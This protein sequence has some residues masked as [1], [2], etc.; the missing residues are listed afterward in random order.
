MQ[1]SQKTTQIN[2]N[3]QKILVPEDS[4]SLP[5]TFDPLD[6]ALDESGYIYIADR[7][8]RAIYRWSPEGSLI[9]TIGGPGSGPG[10]FEH[11]PI[12]LAIYDD[13]LLAAIDM[14]TGKLLLYYLKPNPAFD[15]TITFPSA[16]ASVDW[17]SH[18]KLIV[19]AVPMPSS[20]GI[21]IVH[22][23]NEEEKINSLELPVPKHPLYGLQLVSTNANKIL[24]A[25]I[26]INR[27]SMIDNKTNQINYFSLKDLPPKS[28]EQDSFEDPLFGQ[29]ML[30]SD[31][32]IF[33]MAQQDT[34]QFILTASSDLSAPQRWLWIFSYSET[35]PATLWKLSYAARSLAV[36]DRKVYILDREGLRLYIYTW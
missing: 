29:I 20:N 6:I 13:S 18:D 11:G 35:R 17:L 10:E 26:F 1:S 34:L 8:S 5:L 7:N 30:P 2:F 12:S 22:I 33:D 36:H 27:I 3:N 15:R 24:L 23:K 14:Q 31:I 21:N 28:P 4:L 16:L 19:S 9:D 32:L 25:G